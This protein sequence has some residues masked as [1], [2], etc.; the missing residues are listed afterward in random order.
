[1]NDHDG[2]TYIVRLLVSIDQLGNT[3]LPFAWGPYGGYP[4]E[5]ISSCL[6]KLARD[7]GGKIPWRYFWLKPLHWGL[8]KIDEDHCEDAIEHD[9]GK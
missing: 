6:G 5:T 3:L 1:M 4:D 8:N 9:E 2:K 7:N